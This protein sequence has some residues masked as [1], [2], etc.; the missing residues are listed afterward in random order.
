MKQTLAILLTGLSLNASA[1]V[2]VVPV[3]GEITPLSVQPVIAQ[4]KSATSEDTIQLMINSPGGSLMAGFAVM[5]A[6][7]NSPAKKICRLNG[8]AASM[9]AILMLTCEQ[10]YIDAGSVLMFHLPYIPTKEAV[11]SYKLR[12]YMVSKYLT[13]ILQEKYHLDKLM[14]QKDWEKLIMGDD[15]YYFGQREII[16][17][18]T[19][20]K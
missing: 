1:A 18:L 16:P 20:K 7:D 15:V 14:G 11:D 5:H 17:L 10:K 8:M 3:T 12:D 4:I 13:T 2:V 19:P 9:A 6:I